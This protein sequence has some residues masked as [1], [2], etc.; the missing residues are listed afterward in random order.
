MT[1][2]ASRSERQD[3]A[4]RPRVLHV[5][6]T[7]ALGGIETWLVHMLRH[8]N[9][10]SVAHEILLTVDSVGPY[11]EEVRSLGI[12][13]HRL[14]LAG[15]KRRWF[16]QFSALLKREGPFAAVHSHAAPHL[17][18]PLLSTARRAG[19]PVRI[20]HSH[21]ARSQ[22]KDY[23]LR[24]RI[25]RR[26]AVP[27]FRQVATRRIGITDAAI[28]E[29]AGPNWRL[30]AGA[31]VLIYGFDFDRYRGAAER[32][33][34][35][36]E[37]LGIPE[38]APVVGSVARFDK[39]KN[40]EFL[41][42]AFAACLR[43]L[44][45]ARLVLVGKGPLRE[46]VEQQARDLGIADKVLFAGTTE[47]VA[48]YM[49]M[50]DLFALPS[51]SEGL[52]IVVVEAQAAGTRALVSETTPAEAAVVP[53]AVEVLPLSAGAEAWGEA[54]ARLLKLP[55][56]DAADWLDKVEASRFGIRRCID[57]LDSIYRSELGRA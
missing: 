46:S 56:P 16:G 20:A 34:E 17:A 12:P 53:G 8:K 19:V 10:F 13:I 39:V 7:L 5:I 54:M 40:H 52:G 31:S 37:S 50:F 6:G 21:S 55:R 38:E 14:P 45:G 4:A 18:A 28:E 41:L 23:P 36:R 25:A 42:R 29:I 15:N 35:V 48:A 32:A 26:L 27:W 30:E 47:D 43:D 33:G 51:F 2:Q 24:L 3:A 11:E 22:G 44:P 49:A 57:E 1:D 9:E